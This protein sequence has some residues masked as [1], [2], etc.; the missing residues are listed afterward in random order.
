MSIR[1]L[2]GITVISLEHAIAAP[3]CTRQLADLGARVIKVE[4]PGSGD[5]A[6]GYD[7]QVKG[8]SSHFLWVNRSKESLCLDLKQPAALAA[9]KTLLKTADVLVQN[10]APGAA[11]RMGLTAELLQKDNPHLILCDIS[12]YGN[13]GSYR[14][15]KAYDLLIQSEAGF[16]SVTGT[17]ESPSKAGNSIADIA[18]GMYAYTNILAALLQRGKTGKGSVIDVSMLEAL[19]EWMS[20]PM[21]YAFEGAEPPPRNGASH[22]TIYPYGPF[23]AGDGGTVMLGLQNE[24]EWAQ[25]CDVVL[26]DP[27]LALD[28]RFDKNFKRNEKRTELLAII[29]Q[30]FSKLTTE[31]VIAKLEKAQIANARLNDMKGLWNHQQLKERDRW[32][33]VDTPAGSIPALLPPGLNNTYDY[34]MDPIPSVGEHT[35][36]ILKELGLSDSDIANMRSSGAI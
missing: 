36:A 32:V 34:R 9:L 7:K 12:G 28:E 21:Y 24:R 23:K 10:L 13:N 25:F 2:D 5:F 30:C 11:A 26:E 35:D 33:N 29:D 14:D 18:A 8:Q 20:F 19:G 3:F 22:A 17:P 31:Q 27:V 6:R 1:P 4:R 15:K 16:L